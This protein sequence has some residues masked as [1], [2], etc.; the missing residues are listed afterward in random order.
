MSGLI[1]SPANGATEIPGTSADALFVFL[2][3]PIRHWWA[4]GM[5]DSLEHQAYTAFRTL[6]HYELSADFL[7][8]APHLAWRGPWNEGAQ[9]VNNAAVAACDALVWLDIPGVVAA[10][11]AAEVA[12]AERAGIVTHRIWVGDT[13]GLARVK[14]TLTRADR[15]RRAVAA[16]AAWGSGA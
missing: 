4:P 13:D 9:A 14:A 16:M 12:T 2:A 3:G 8:Y 6:V 10:G 1:D 5:W 15:D 7:V 11:T